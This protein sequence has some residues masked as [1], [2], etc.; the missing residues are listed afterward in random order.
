MWRLISSPSWLWQARPVCLSESWI[1]L[2]FI[3]NYHDN[4]LTLISYSYCLGGCIGAFCFCCILV[5]FQQAS[6]IV[7]GSNIVPYVGTEYVSDF[8]FFF[9]SL[10]HANI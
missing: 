4:Y 2:L 3:Q 1:W 5:S 6:R 7:V 8:F 10:S 9:L